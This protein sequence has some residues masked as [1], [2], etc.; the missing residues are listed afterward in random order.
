MP[1]EIIKKDPSSWKVPPNVACYQKT[2]AEFSW[3]SIR[4]ELEG[5]PG[6]RGLN[7]AHEAVDRHANGA[8]RNQLALRW[9]RREGKAVDFT[10]ADLQ[11]KTNRFANVLSQLGSEGDAIFA[12]AGRIPEPYIA[13]LGAR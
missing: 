7:I 2:C 13:A 6:G 1:W 8:R 3:D 11:D 12:L 9:L 4:R 5:L 10:Y